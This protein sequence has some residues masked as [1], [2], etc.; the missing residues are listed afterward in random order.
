MFIKKNADLDVRDKDGHS[1]LFYA[2]D[3]NQVAAS[4]LL[5]AGGADARAVQRKVS[6][7]G[8]TASVG[9]FEMAVSSGKF[10]ACAVLQLLTE[11]SRVTCKCMPE[12]DRRLADLADCV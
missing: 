4:K 9:A 7:T 1:T 10:P 2:I 8:E 11:W 3:H 6:S 5:I 12:L